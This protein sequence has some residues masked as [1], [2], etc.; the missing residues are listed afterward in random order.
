MSKQL[1]FGNLQ[2][3]SHQPKKIPTMSSY[4]PLPTTTPPPPSYPPFPIEAAEPA[5]RIFISCLNDS[6][7]TAFAHRRPLRE[8]I[9][10]TAFSRPMSLSDATTR[11]RK[12][13]SYFR[14]NYLIIIAFVL[15]FSIVSHPFSLFTLMTLVA[16]W[17]LYVF[18]PP[19][20]PLVVHNRTFSENETL[21]ILILLT[22]FVVFLTNVGSV[23]MSSV[24]TG[25]GIVCVHG[26]FRDPS[27]LFLDEQDIAAASGLFSLIGGAASSAAGLPGPKVVYT[28]PRV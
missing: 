22:V 26:A 27:D 18:R 10:Y 23:F 20:Q 9:N 8:L 19:D 1:D 6:V 21:G 25:V 16:L 2:K 7:R 13:A 12:N 3:S 17:L 28:R 14:A 24:L 11:L 15:T 4:E 5:I